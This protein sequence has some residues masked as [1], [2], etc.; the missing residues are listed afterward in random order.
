V[1]KKR[2]RAPLITAPMLKDG[3]FGDVG[4]GTRWLGRLADVA[5]RGPATSCYAA[6]SL[7][8]AIPAVAL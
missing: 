3:G 4:R 2:E 7:T 6:P 8:R 1:A 5:I